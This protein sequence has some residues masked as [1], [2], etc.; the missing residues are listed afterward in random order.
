MLSREQ[1]IFHRPSAANRRFSRV[2]IISCSSQGSADRALRI[3][4]P[5]DSYVF[6]ERSKQKIKQLDALRSQHPELVD[7]ITVEYGDANTQLVKF[8]SECDWKKNRAVVFLD[9][10]G[11]QVEWSTICAIAQTQAID[12]WYLFPAGLGVYRQIGRDGRVDITHGGSLDR[13]FGTT[14]WRDAFIEQQSEPDLFAEHRSVTVKSATPESITRYMIER[15]KQVFA[16]GVLDEWLAL[17]SRN[18]HMYS[19]LFAWANPS[20]S[21]RLA[22]KLARAVLRSKKRGRP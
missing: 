1:A 19:L 20:G 6:V 14:D 4:K 3:A 18:I 5:F 16:G 13:L 2:R 10:F 11:N 17:G 12:L 22:G 15:M 7:R 21:A 9:P 8:C